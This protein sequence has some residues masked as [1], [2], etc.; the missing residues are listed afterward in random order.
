MTEILEQLKVNS[1]FFIEFSLF[2]IF[3]VLLSAIYLKPVQA[4]LLA[5]RKK[6]GDEVQSSN[7]LL[8]SI[9]ARLGDY[10]KQLSHARQEA[11]KSYENA[12]QEVKTSEDAKINAVKDE[13]KKDYMKATQQLQEEKK[14]IE[15]EL[16]TQVNQLADALSEK[17]LGGK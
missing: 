11:I 4:V 16:A 12:V 15:A 8:K 5:R 10:E 6:L 7:E 2:V 17:A 9:E 3:F 14:K 1:S 13:L